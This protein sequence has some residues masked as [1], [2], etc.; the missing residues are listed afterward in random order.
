MLQFLCCL[1]SIIFCFVFKLVLRYVVVHC[2][3]DIFDAHILVEVPITVIRA[4]LEVKLFYGNEKFI[5]WMW[6][7]LS[8][9]SPVI[10]SAILWTSPGLC[11]TQFESVFIECYTFPWHNH[12]IS[13]NTSTQNFRV[14]QGLSKEDDFACVVSKGYTSSPV[15]HLVITSQGY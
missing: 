12:I 9:C 6:F 2:T 5:L 15:L 4:I 13:C 3:V 10:T 7:Q 1:L 14:M 8:N 11:I